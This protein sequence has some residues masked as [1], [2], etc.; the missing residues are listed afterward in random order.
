[1]SAVATGETGRGVWDG[2]IVQVPNL[3]DGDKI[4]LYTSTWCLWV[5]VRR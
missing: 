5:P 3:V 4:R 2:S 1:M